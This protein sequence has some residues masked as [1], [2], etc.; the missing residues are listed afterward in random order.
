MCVCVVSGERSVEDVRTGDDQLP[1]QVSSDPRLGRPV[2]QG[3]GA[4]QQRRRHEALAVL[5]GKP[6]PT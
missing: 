3:E 1:E 5:Q 4:H 2:Q 6:H